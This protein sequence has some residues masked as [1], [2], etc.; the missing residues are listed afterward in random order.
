MH[1]LDLQV[2]V[3]QVV[4]DCVLAEHQ[5]HGE[6]GRVQDR[7]RDVG[8]DHPPHHRKPAGAEAS[9]GFGQRLDV[10]GAESGVDRPIAIGKHEHNVREREGQDGIAEVVVQPDIHGEQTHHEDDGGDGQRQQRHELDDPGEPR[11]LEAHPDHRGHQKHEHD[12]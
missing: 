5:R 8:H 3:Q 7:V 9:R 11:Q 4:G 2:V 1:E 12:D 10:D 6:Q